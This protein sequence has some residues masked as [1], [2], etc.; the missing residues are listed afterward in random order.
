MSSPNKHALIVCDMQPD[1]LRSLSPTAAESVLEAVRIAVDC[2]LHS[3]Y[4]KWT[5]IFHGLA[6]PASYQGLDPQ[7]RIYGALKRINTLQGDERAHWFLE[8]YPGSDLESSLASIVD[9]AV[10]VSKNDEKQ[11]AF[12]WRQSHLPSPALLELIR[13][14]GI[15]HA[16]IVGVKV[17]HAVQVTAQVLTDNG[18]SVSV[19]GDSVADDCTKRQQAVLEHVLPVFANI[20][21][22]ESLVD[23]TIG[24]DPFVNR[25]AKRLKEKDA[26]I[27]KAATIQD[28]C[29]CGRGLHMALYSQ[30]LLERGTW[31]KYPVQHWYTSNREYHCPLGKKIMAF[32]DEPQFSAV[33]MYIAGREWLD[34]KEK[35]IALVAAGT[36]P[37][38]YVVEDGR[39]FSGDDTHL[40]CIGELSTM[41][42][43]PWF[44]KE[45]D[46]NGGRAIKICHT[47]SDCK[48]LLAK[49]KNGC[50]S[51]YVVQAHIVDPL[52]TVD[53]HKC[54]VKFYSLLQ[55]DAD[56][57]SWTLHVYQDA[58][59]CVSPVKWSVGD[60]SPTT[61]ITIL[62]EKCLR[63]GEEAE[64]WTGWPDAYGSCKEIIAKVV[65]NAVAQGKLKGRPG[66]K[67][68]E[69]FSSDFL[70]DVDGKS[71]LIECNFGPSMFDPEAN[72]PLTTKGLQEY[73]RRYEAEGDRVQVNDR[74]M[75]GDAVCMVFYPEEAAQRSTRWDPAGAFQGEAAVETGS[76][77][78]GTSSAVAA[79]LA[80]MVLG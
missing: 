51:K 3:S 5:V 69:I 15:S 19:I 72:Q 68:F 27:A 60:L 45:C 50:S 66:K 24:L 14:K 76:S 39:W 7:H 9:E 12:V 54:H 26:E 10:K 36:M 43:G 25:V 32:C 21:S 57:Q 42:K 62:R 55:C 18:V 71:W 52:L 79:S 16:T 49:D 77:S 4:G 30:H 73:Q 80:A 38:T 48:T 63:V 64:E 17:G 78:V 74:R 34:E 31:R 67:Q 13:S 44:V 61:Q 75:I 11:V 29:D 56:A 23:S 58:F 40:E 28:S 33:S 59:L 46:K 37:E 70:V 47:L 8:G 20:V 65:G 1:A 2:C 53:E 41:T 22:L 6:F 35:V